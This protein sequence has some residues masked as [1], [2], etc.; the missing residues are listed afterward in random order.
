MN[1]TGKNSMI[2]NR[3]DVHLNPFF[4]NWQFHAFAFQAVTYP[5]QRAFQNRLFCAMDNLPAVPAYYLVIWF[6]KN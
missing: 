6:L 4:P 1:S 5:Q 2:H 3:V